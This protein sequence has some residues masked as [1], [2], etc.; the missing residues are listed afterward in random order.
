MHKKTTNYKKSARRA[1]NILYKAMF[2]AKAKRIKLE[3]LGK[4][5][6]GRF[7][8]SEAFSNDD[9]TNGLLHVCLHN[10]YKMG[11]LK[12]KGYDDCYITIKDGVITCPGKNSMYLERHGN[13][14]SVID[15]DKWPENTYPRIDVYIDPANKKLM[16]L[17][18]KN[19]ACGE[20]RGWNII[21]KE[22][23]I[24]LEE[25]GIVIGNVLEVH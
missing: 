9:Y 19:A 10:L 21:E 1:V 18:V 12:I 3:Q 23:K 16:V 24:T 6:K 7:W 8:F 2:P 5:K 4:R 22:E 13:G 25:N 15:I 14:F 11:H 20:G 17:S